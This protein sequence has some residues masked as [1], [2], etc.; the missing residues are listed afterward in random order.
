MWSEQGLSGRLLPMYL[1]GKFTKIAYIKYLGHLDL[2]SIL[3]KALKRAGMR[4]TYSQ[5]FNP[6]PNLS[7]ANPLPLGLESEAEFI[8][9]ET[10][11]DLDLAS[12]LPRLNEELPRGI[13]FEKLVPSPRLKLDKEIKEISYRLVFEEETD[14][15]SLGQIMDR[16]GGDDDYLVMREKIHKKRTYKVPFNLTSFLLAYEVDK[17]G[18]TLDYKSKANIGGNLRPET[19]V[20]AFNK[21][22]M[23]LDYDSIRVIR[24]GQYRDLGEPII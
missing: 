11:D 12:F 9:I 13:V 10:E 3:A 14:M 22:A 23:G 7:I 19:L 5:G 20:Q 8:Q 2:I 24:T 17:E 1:I 4:V 15:D 6:T 16:I 18:L 21:E